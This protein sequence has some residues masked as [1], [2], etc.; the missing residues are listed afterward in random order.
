MIELGLTGGIGSG[1]STVARILVEH[2]GAALVDADHIAR[3]VTG[4]GGAAMAAIQEAFGADFV[5]A[6]GALHRER[7]RTHVFSRP[8]ARHTLEAIIH[9][10]VLGLSQERAQAA[11][12]GGHNL[13]VFD[14]PLLVESGHW[15]RRLGAVWVVD[16]L[17]S[18]QMNR[19]MARNGLAPAVVQKIMASQAS[20]RQRCAT[21]DGV[22]YNDGLDLA[23]LQIQVTTLVRTLGQTLGQR[24][25]L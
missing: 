20:R 7:M 16:C 17:E 21:A 24:L 14:V 4:A 22:I 6:T 5:D 2:H 18:T 10:W 13:V 8:V 11:Q 25:G 23:E 15:P 19:V 12:A 9:P 1:K 3:E